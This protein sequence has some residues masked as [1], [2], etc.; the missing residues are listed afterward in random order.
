MSEG[1]SIGALYYTVCEVIPSSVHVIPIL[2]PDNL[3][4]LSTS[5]PPPSR[6]SREGGNPAASVPRVLIRRPTPRYMKRNRPIEHPARLRESLYDR[7]VRLVSRRRGA[8][9]R[10]LPDNALSSMYDRGKTK[11]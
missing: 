7:R 1:G 2:H 9:A 11:C 6:H 5:F 10:G 4:P 3:H 8:L